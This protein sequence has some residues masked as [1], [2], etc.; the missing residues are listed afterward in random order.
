[1]LAH[2]IDVLWVPTEGIEKSIQGISSLSPSFLSISNY[3]NFGRN[4]FPGEIWNLFTSFS[5]KS[6][7]ERRYPIFGL[8][9]YQ[10]VQ[11]GQISFFTL[12]RPV[13]LVYIRAWEL[14]YPEQFNSIYPSLSQE[15]LSVPRSL[16]WRFEFPSVENSIPSGDLVLPSLVSPL[17]FSPSF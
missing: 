6:F 3:F 2:E 4:W 7:L 8:V 9:F 14:L 16:P 13:W 10:S 15:E 5:I 17:L 12:I 11:T 1:M